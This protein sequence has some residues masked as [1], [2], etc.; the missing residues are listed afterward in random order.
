[1]T[2]VESVVKTQLL[3][4]CLLCSL[5]YVNCDAHCPSYSR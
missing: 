4:I 5:L 2:E 1:M 3:V